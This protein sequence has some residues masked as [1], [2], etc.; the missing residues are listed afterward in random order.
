M[1][2]MSH[3]HRPPLARILHL[4]FRRRLPLEGE[5]AV[6]IL[7]STLDVFATWYLLKHG[8]GEQKRFVESNPIPRYFLLSWGFTSLVY[9]KFSLVALVSVIGQVIAR[10]RIEV[11]R[12]LLVFAS[13]IVAGVVIYSLALIVQ[14]ASVPVLD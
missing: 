11:A 14:H 13:L 12:R 6:F 3:E 4:L 9:F 7:V 2:E 5:T 8:S 1:N 10:R